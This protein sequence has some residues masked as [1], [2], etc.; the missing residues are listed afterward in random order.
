[1]DKYAYCENIIKESSAT[2]YKAFSA[3]EPRKAQA[4]YA[5]YAFCRTV[6]NAIDIHNDIDKLEALERGIRRVFDGDIPDD[7]MF[8]ALAETLERFPNTIDPYINLIDGMRDDFYKKPIETSEDFDQY[9]YKAAST[10]GLMLIPILAQKE[11]EKDSQPLKDV[12]I[13]L[14]KAMQITNILR[15]VREDLTAMR[16]YFPQEVL[17]KQ[18]INLETLR[19][20]IVTPEYRSM[21]EQYI[22]LAEEKYSVF[23]TNAH[24]FDEDARLQTVVAAKFYE[25]ILQEIRRADYNNLTKRHYVSTLRKRHLFKQAQKELKLKGLWA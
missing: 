5:V 16:V 6:D 12:A 18:N 23:Y 24:L 1:M 14:G 2:F 25:G 13:E 15:D 22:T 4:V 9:C 19:T 21:I 11:Y 20:G 10:V 8:Q 17:D 3:L 7:L